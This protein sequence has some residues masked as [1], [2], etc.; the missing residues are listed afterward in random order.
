MFV[1]K[2]RTYVFKPYTYYYP[3]QTGRLEKK[4]KQSLLVKLFDDPRCPEM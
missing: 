1:Y 4:T 3:C 2:N